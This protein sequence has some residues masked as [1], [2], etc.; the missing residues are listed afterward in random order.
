MHKHVGSERRVSPTSSVVL[1]ALTISY[2]EQCQGPFH[3][4]ML[5]D[6][7]PNISPGDSVFSSLYVTSQSDFIYSVSSNIHSKQSIAGSFSWFGA[8]VSLFS[9]AF[10]VP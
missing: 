3:L 8:L 1:K 9:H 4:F 7:K 5:A 6:L 10:S 2:P